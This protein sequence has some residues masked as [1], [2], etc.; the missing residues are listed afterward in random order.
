MSLGGQ[1]YL[2]IDESALDEL[3]CLANT[4]ECRGAA[5]GAEVCKYQPKLF[6]TVRVCS[7]KVMW[8]RN[9]QR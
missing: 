4:V 6:L 2:E 9:L 1:Q 7:G 8:E 5:L 3:F